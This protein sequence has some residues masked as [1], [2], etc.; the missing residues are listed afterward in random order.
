MKK[1]A[2]ETAEQK[3]YRHRLTWK[4]VILYLAWFASVVAVFFVSFNVFETD[5]QS[6]IQPQIN[7]AVIQVAKLLPQMEQNEATLRDSYNQ[8]IQ[9]WENILKSDDFSISGS[10]S[11]NWTDASFEELV[12]DTLSWLNRVTKLKVGRDGLVAVVSKETGRIVAHPDEKLV[13]GEFYIEEDPDSKASVIVSIEAINAL[14]SPDDLKISYGMLLPHGSD[15]DRLGKLEQFTATWKQAIFG[16]AISYGDFY[17]VC[18]VPA[19]E[20][21][22]S[23]ILNALL[24]TAIYLVAMWF[25]VHWIC[26][27][28]DARRETAK[29]MRNKLVTIA[30]LM[31]VA[32]FGISFYV[33]HLSNVAN[34]LKTMAKH[35]DV[36]VD[37]LNAYDAQSERLNDYMDGYYLVQCR[38]AAAFIDEKGAENLTPKDVQ[39]YADAL[40]VKC[41]YVFDKSGNVIVTNSHFDSFELSEDPAHY[42]NQ[43]RRVLEGLDQV[44]LSPLKDEWR[45]EYIQYLAVNRRDG[46]DQNNG[47]VLIGVDPGMRDSLLKPLS[48]NTVLENLVIGLPDYALAVDKASMMIAATTGLGYKGSPIEDLGITADALVNKYCGT[49]AING[50]EYY[51]GVAESSDYYLITAMRSSDCFSTIVNSLKLTLVALAACFVII[52][53]TLI[54]YQEVVI[55]GAPEAAEPSEDPV[56]DEDAASGEEAR[57]NLLSGISNILRIHERNDM[58]DRWG[59]NDI[60]KDQMTPEQRIG[61]LVYWLLLLFC[62]LILL[63]TLY[64]SLNGKIKPYDLNNLAYVISGNWQKGVNIFALTTCVFLLCIMYVVVVLLNQILYRIA[65]YS[66]MRV[67]TVCLLLKNAVKYVCVIAFVYYGLSQFGVQTQTLLASA[68]ILSMMISFGA[69]DLVGDIIAGFFTIV[70]GTYKVG[71]FITVGGWSGIVVEIGLRTTKIRS[72]SDTKVISNSAIRDVVNSNGEVAR[73]VLK[74]PISYDADLTEVE[75]ILDEE[76]PKL[77]DV[78][79]GLVKPPQY[80]GIESLG[81]SSVNLRIVIFVKNSKKYPALRSLTREIKLLFDQRGIEIPFNQLV[82]HNA[83]EAEKGTEK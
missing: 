58:Q 7:C 57:Y 4:K 68:G 74:A 6:R 59:M 28:M 54:R 5:Y 3:Q 34:D 81:D 21:I 11:R 53:L 77:M 15:F 72:F 48:V 46:N 33:Q 13:G 36:A 52:L 82:L 66:D 64:E 50:E 47:L 1:H 19:I 16:S 14:A 83:P 69:K 63:P 29:S 73:M 49:L 31:C 30:A 12:G 56:P 37:T 65:K 71:D 61:K 70:E 23:V 27:E 78:I 42:S 80:E 25:F 9:S 35:A 62:L 10:F 76:L 51:A 17:I 24:I 2:N 39:R 60:P 45:D 40:K 75:T 32:L 18:G 41:I 43:F 55:D 26:L 38:L 67:E 22:T 44:V 8:M 79:P 20:F